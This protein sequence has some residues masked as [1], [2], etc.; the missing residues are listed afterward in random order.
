MKKI[1]LLI[2]CLV[3]IL[4]N[5]N[6]Q[7]I[8][9]SRTLDPKVK[10]KKAAQAFA[11][12]G[13]N[14]GLQNGNLEQW[15]LD[16]FETASG[17]TVKFYHPEMWAPVNGFM[18]SYFFD[19]PVP[20]SAVFDVATSNTS[21]RIE[22][23]TMDIGSDLATLFAS[24]ER[25]LTVNGQYEFT[26]GPK[27][28]YVD[29][30]ATKYDALADSTIIVGA[31]VFE[32]YTNTNGSFQNFSAD[33]QYIDETVI[34]DTFYVIVSYIEGAKGTWFK[35]DNI[36]VTYQTTSVSKEKANRLAVYPNPSS[37]KIYVS[38]IDGK[39]VENAELTILSMDGSVK[40]KQT[41][42]NSND[43]INLSDL[44]KG[45]YILSVN[46]GQS[47]ITKKISKI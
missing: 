8:S 12:K 35:F 47:I 23:D 25:V 11:Q 16:S 45:I 42:Y 26:G 17:S 33:I 38:F 31:G 3:V 2:A 41:K 36:S 13:V 15:A 18:F 19:I 34:P 7:S 30:Y 43:A 4:A 5:S 24:K 22:I 10:I 44:P 37:D 46:D 29:V 32:T 20:I 9:S 39:K 14:T 21:A 27:G 28:A 6:A 40:L 1:L